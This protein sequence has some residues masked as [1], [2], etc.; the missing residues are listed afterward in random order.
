MKRKEKC[1]SGI[2]IKMHSD[3][4]YDWKIPY[5]AHVLSLL[6]L[7]S[8]ISW[9]PSHFKI[10][11]FHFFESRQVLGSKNLTSKFQRIAKLTVYRAHCTECTMENNYSRICWSS[12]RTFSNL[13]F[14]WRENTTHWKIMSTDHSTLCGWKWEIFLDF[15]TFSN[16]FL[17]GFGTG[18]NFSIFGHS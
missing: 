12:R 1:S 3:Y 14:Y 16:R 17:K 10:L 15:K 7:R 6:K 11:I 13:S 18:T 8:L 9:R 5:W 4:H 2:H